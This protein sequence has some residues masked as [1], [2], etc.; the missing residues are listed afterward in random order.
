MTEKTYHV[1]G[2]MSGTSLDGLDLA[3]CEFRKNRD[4]WQYEILKAVTY[5]YPERWKEYLMKASSLHV[6]AF[7]LLHNEYGRFLGSAVRKSRLA[8][9]LMYWPAALY[10]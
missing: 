6:R 8:G 5:E 7:L 9:R 10:H 3:L 1:V 2:M 4:A